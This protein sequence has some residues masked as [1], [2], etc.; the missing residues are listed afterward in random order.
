MVPNKNG[1]LGRGKPG[2]IT[3]FVKPDLRLKATPV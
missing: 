1:D 3:I 2:V